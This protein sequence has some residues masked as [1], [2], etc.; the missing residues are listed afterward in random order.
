VE[1][2]KAVEEAEVVVKLIFDCW[3]FFATIASQYSFVIN[4]TLLLKQHDNK[5]CFGLLILYH[6]QIQSSPSL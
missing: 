2:A 3:C 5:C 6:L 4:S 1:E